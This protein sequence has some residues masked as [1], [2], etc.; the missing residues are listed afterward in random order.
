MMMMLMMM[1]M[2]WFMAVTDGSEQEDQDQETMHW[3]YPLHFGIY[4]EL[5]YYVPNHPR[6]PL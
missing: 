6:G 4:E 3:I 1:T 2:Q 5:W